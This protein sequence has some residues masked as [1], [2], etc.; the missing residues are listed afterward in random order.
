MKKVL[1]MIII[2]AASILLFPVVCHAENPIVQTR[3]TADPAP[4]VYNGTCYL[5]TG[6]DEDGSTYY[7]MND[8]RCYSST[9]MVN[10]VDCGSPLSYSTFSWAK[11]DAWA[12]QCIPRNGKF[13]YYVPVNQKNG[14]MA[15]GVAVSDSPT[16]PF[17]DALGHPLASTGTGDIDPTVFIDDNG[18]AYLYWG[19]PN[20]YYV[21]LNQDMISYSGSIVKVP[22]TTEGFGV[23]NG[24]AQKPTLYEEGPWF[25]KQN[26]M[27]YMV[28]AAGGIPEYICY[29]TSTSPTGPWQY[30]GKIMPTQGKSFT[31]HP[32]V[33]DYKGNS[34]FFYHNGALPGGS[35]FTRSVCVE[36]FKYNA[37][38][39]FPTINMT[40]TGVPA[41][42]NLN[43]YVKTEA[44]TICTES[45]VQTEKCSEGGQNISNIE[46]GDWIKVKGVNFGTGAASFNA[47]VASATSGGNIEL[48]LDSPT[49]TLIGTCSVQG[50][51][52]WQ[53]WVNKSC[54]VSGAKGV[55]DLYLKFTGGNGYL[56]N[57]NWWQ[58][59]SND[60]TGGKL[61]YGGD[62]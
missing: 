43:P 14:G 18:Q 29:S 17:K 10:W 61:S 37:D 23:R 53:S 54:K 11:G 50:T 34:Y 60:S 42:S 13:Y 39:T 31:N 41:I 4:M 20:L 27:Y 44:E 32:G 21:K 38:G 30:R 5:Y 24:N 58:F 52:G 8:W 6:H 16:G 49:G 40:T 56:L 25:Y 22:L 46:N 28:Y 15:I 33:I 57:V 7:T 51:G 55:H 45:G 36:Q 1:S 62:N 48:R 12:G 35:G 9:D 2:S 26:G 59:S 3:Y 19:N 47:R